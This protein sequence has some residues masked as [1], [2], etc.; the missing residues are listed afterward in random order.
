MKKDLNWIAK[1]EKAIAQKYGFEAIENP[2]KHWTPEKEEKHQKETEEFYRRKY[3]KDTKSS[4]ENYK[5]FLI[6]KKL[7]TRESDRNCPVCGSYSFSAQDD[8]YMQRYKCCF[9]CYVTWVEDR[10][11]RWNS[12]WRPNKEQIDGN[13]T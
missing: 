8:L 10:E 4:K 2:K 9:S 6:N 5:G 1:L 13:N 11:A 12:G 3:F 7:L